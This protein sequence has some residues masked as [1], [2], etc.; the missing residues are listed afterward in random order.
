MTVLNKVTFPNYRPYVRFC[1]VDKPLDNELLESFRGNIFFELAEDLVGTYCSMTRSY[2]PF[3]AHGFTQLS[4]P[5]DIY[6]MTSNLMMW[7]FQLARSPDNY[8]WKEA[9][10]WGESHQLLNG[11]PYTGE[12]FKADLIETLHFIIGKMNDAA[13]N[14]HCV[15]IAG[16]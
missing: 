10:F 15:I 5:Y 3:D 2:S 6:L 7:A 9:T 12:R 16:V 14:N 13:A 8:F 4:K 11:T 1:V